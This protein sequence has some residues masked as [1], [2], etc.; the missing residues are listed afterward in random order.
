MCPVEERAS[1]HTKPSA[2]IGT[3]L[4]LSRTGHRGREDGTSHIFHPL[5]AIKT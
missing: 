4:W 1:D 3:Q 5:S 2:R